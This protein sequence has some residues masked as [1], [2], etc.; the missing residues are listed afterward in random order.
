MIFTEIWSQQTLENHGVVAPGQGAALTGQALTDAMAQIPGAMEMGPA[1]GAG[2][3]ISFITSLGIAFV[4]GMV[5]PASLAGALRV[6]LVLWV[7]FAATTLAYNIVYSSE[8]RII[9][10][11]D[12]GHLFLGYMLAA[13]LIFLIDGKAIRR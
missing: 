6:A 3:L 2:F 7:G 10:A 9:Y 13:T 8:S 4:L 5:R 12:L 11:I 1:L